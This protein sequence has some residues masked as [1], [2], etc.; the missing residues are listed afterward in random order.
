MDFIGSLL[1]IFV[2]VL[3]IILVISPFESLQWWAGWVS[4]DA[5]P[6]PT[7]PQAESDQRQPD[8]IIVFLP[9]VGA[10]GTQVDPW[11]QRLVDRLHDG[12]RGDVVLSGLFPFTVR[13]DTLTEHRRTAWF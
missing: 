1:T 2:V 3:L 4:E 13:D 12:L 6:T 11:E 7:S 8:R 5:A 10:M 9:G